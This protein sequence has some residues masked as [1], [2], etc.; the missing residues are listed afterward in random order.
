MPDVIKT[1]TKNSKP[2]FFGAL[3]GSIK[4]VGAGFAMLGLAP[5]LIFWNECN[6]VEVAQSLEEGAGAVVAVSADAVDPNNEGALVHMSGQ[7]S[8]TESVSDGQFGVSGQYLKLERSVEMYQW[9]ENATEE[10]R[11]D[12]TV[13]TY[14]YMREWSNSV[15]KTADFQAEGQVGHENPTTWLY[16]GDAWSANAVSVGAFLLS[17]SQIGQLSGAVSLTPDADMSA[18]GTLLNGQLYSGDPGNPLVGDYRIKWSVIHPGPVSLVASQSGTSFEPYTT[19]NDRQISLLE[20]GVL[21]ETEMFEVAQQRNN[22]MTWILRIISFVCIFLG[23]NLVVGPL[24][25]LADR[26]PILGGIFQAGMLVISFLGSAFL[27][28]VAVGLAWLSARPLL[29]IALLV[30]SAGAFFGMLTLVIL[31]VRKYKATAAASA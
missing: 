11:D 19:S 4:R 1:V 2:G 30:V 7:A 26:V 25:V 15:E 20:M 3:I 12:E 16:E 10:N 18:H 28:T 17:D 21:S 13:T 22:T 5:I 14:T 23:I 8:T 27:W 29:G 24:R 6:S 9:V 31:G